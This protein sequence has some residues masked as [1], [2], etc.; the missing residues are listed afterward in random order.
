MYFAKSHEID[1]DIDLSYEE[2]YGS[3]K[4]ADEESYPIDVA[5]TVC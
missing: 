1:L 5:Q 2:Q 3:T 4:F